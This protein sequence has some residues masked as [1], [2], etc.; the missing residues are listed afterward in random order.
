MAV[1]VGVSDMQ[2]VTGDTRHV[3]PDIYI[4]FFFAL[5]LLSTHVKRFSVSC[6]REVFVYC[7]RKWCQ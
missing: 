1:A 4:F 2:K 3:T 7:H 5:V 6:M